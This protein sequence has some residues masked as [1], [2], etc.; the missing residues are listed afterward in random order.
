MKKILILWL[1]LLSL[2]VTATG[3]EIS[4]SLATG[5][6]TD[7]PTQLTALET[8]LSA[9]ERLI[10]EKIKNRQTPLLLAQMA[11]TEEN[12]VAKQTALNNVKEVIQSLAQAKGLQEQLLVVQHGFSAENE[13]LNSLL[14]EI[15]KS[16]ETSQAIQQLLDNPINQTDLSVEQKN[17]LPMLISRAEALQH[18]AA[19]WSETLSIDEAAIN[20]ANILLATW[21]AAQ[22]KWLSEQKQSNADN[23]KK[24]LMAEKQAFEKKADNL[25]QQLD[26]E[27]G[28]LS[29][30]QQIALQ[31]QIDQARTQAWFSDVD[32][33]LLDLMKHGRKISQP[34]TQQEGLSITDLTRA[35]LQLN[36]LTKQLKTLQDE[37]ENRYSIFQKSTK[38]IGPQT[39]T[40]EKFIEQI[41]LI[42]YQQLLLDSL[43]KKIDHLLVEKKTK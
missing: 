20:H 1:I 15:N 42:T 33:R 23:E 13:Q 43:P 40:D 27:Q 22:H 24:R 8:R 30:T 28:L 2:C 14:I 26:S 36:K 21:I 3:S 32:A 37:V 35:E 4:I 17:R 31:Q 9:A 5:T 34:L 25:Q 6:K 29:T 11:V 10:A 7:M 39:N 16:V 41:K 38:I 12:L 19:N 18:K